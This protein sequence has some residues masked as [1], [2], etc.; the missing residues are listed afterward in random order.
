MLR[1][2]TNSSWIED[3]SR[4]LLFAPVVSRFGE[5]P[6]FVA[7]SRWQ[8][9]RS[10]GDRVC[11]VCETTDFILLLRAHSHFAKAF[12]RLARTEVFKLE[13]GA[14]LALTLCAKAARGVNL[15][16]SLGPFDRLGP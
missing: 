16:E 11:A 13:E 7:V 2:F 4:S 3:W 14:D 5:R 6:I 15:H 10:G 9:R 1:N 8:F 12:D